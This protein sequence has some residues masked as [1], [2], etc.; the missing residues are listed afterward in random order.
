[1]FAWGWGRAEGSRDVEGF[2]FFFFSAAFPE[3]LVSVI[4]H[5]IVIH[6]CST[7][8][9]VPVPRPLRVMSTRLHA[10]CPQ[11]LPSTL[12]GLSCREEEQQGRQQANISLLLSALKDR[13]L[14]QG[15]H[16]RPGVFNA[17]TLLGT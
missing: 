16:S 4:W 2:F 6:F 7:L 12:A 3:L 5:M 14:A 17:H 13:S 15:H 10:L 11:G 8:S 1:M 9:R